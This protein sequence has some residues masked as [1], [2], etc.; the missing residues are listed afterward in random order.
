MRF[1]KLEVKLIL[2]LVLMQY[3]YDVVD[4][5]GNIVTKTP[6]PARD[7]LYQAPPSKPVYE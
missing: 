3:D 6:E 2:S 5:A 7:N 4:V 1:A